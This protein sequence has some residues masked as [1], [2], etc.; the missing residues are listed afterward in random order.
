VVALLP[1]FLIGAIVFALAGPDGK[2]YRV[3]SEAME[4]TI[5]RGQRIH[6]DMGAYDHDQ[7]KIGDV[8]ILHPPLG[9]DTNECGAPKPQD[10]MCARPTPELGSVTFVKRVVGL[11][12]DRLAMREGRLIRNGRPV[13]EPYTKRCGGYD[14][15]DLPRTIRVPAGHYFLLGDNR[16]ASDDSRFWGPVPKRALL[17]RVKDL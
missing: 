7:P 6:V 3:P 16:G 15:C 1:L 13:G 2:P 12:G 5:H 9:A 17:G 4:P 14:G 11:P 8:V 10:Q